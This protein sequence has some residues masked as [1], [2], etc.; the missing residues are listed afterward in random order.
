MKNRTE[1]SKIEAKE[2]TIGDLF[3][4]NF[5]FQI[6]IYQRPLSWALDNFDQLFE[7][8]LDAMNDN[9]KQYFLGA[10]ILQQLNGKN[11]YEL[12]D[13]Q[14]RLTA[15][16]VLLAVIRD[17]TDNKDLK[18]KINNSWIYQKEDKYKKIPPVMR[19][20]PW[21]DLKE[22]FRKYIYTSN[23]TNE[24]IEDF[25]KRKVNFKDTQDPKYHLY[26]AITTFKDKLHQISNLENF[27]TYLLNN[28]Y[29]V[30]IKTSGL[31]SAFRLFSVLNAR[32]LPLSTS[33]LLKSENLGAIRDDRKKELYAS[34]WRNMEEELGREELE[35][36]IGYIRT[37]KTKEKARLGMY[38]EY[39]KL[40]KGGLLE[41]G[42]KFIDFLR[43]IAGIYDDKIL[44]RDINVRDLERR[45]KYKIIVDMMKRFIP[46][47]DWIPPLIAFY[48]KFNSDKY[49]LDFV[50]RLEKK[51]IMEWTAGFSSTERITSLNRIIKLIEDASDPGDVVDRLLLYKGDEDTRGKKA[52]ILDFSRK[53]QIKS[54]LTN[55]LN[56]TQF[57]SIYAGRFAKYILLRID[58]EL[59]DL[60]NFPGYPGTMTVEHVLPQTP[61]KDSKWI[62]IFSEEEKQVWTNKLGN[63]V[64][65]SGRKNSKAQNYDFD[66]KKDVYF[67]QK[68]TPFRITQELENYIRWDIE[69]LS[70]RHQELIKSVQRVFLN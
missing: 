67:K 51:V 45:N 20:T 44:T 59:W 6:P 23:G 25:D 50:S 8:V 16:A 37:I 52:R 65:L 26:E 63:L 39:Q 69:S 31:T 49:L 12:V 56:D 3:S 70:K 55:K 9:E 18:D 38:E 27:V 64:L 42:T 68:S 40:F 4:E 10:V 14:Q 61:S 32:G 54:I 2:T 30:Y 5:M 48:N 41:K 19:I 62:K 15:L 17:F 29:I 28:V 36:I 21:E 46:F 35:N 7:D 1:T 53:E 22:L 47:S 24:F 33:D 11:Q 57:Y 43:G 13:G 58:M 60:E 34:I 66:K